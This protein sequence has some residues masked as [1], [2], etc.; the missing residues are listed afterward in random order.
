MALLKKGAQVKFIATGAEYEADEIGVLKTRP[1]AKKRAKHRR[2]W[3][4]YHRYKKC[5]RSKK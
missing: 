4:H 5:K 2:C 1:R 3:L